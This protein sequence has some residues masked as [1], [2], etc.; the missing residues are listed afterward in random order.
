MSYHGGIPARAMEAAIAPSAVIDNAFVEQVRHD[1]LAFA[2]LQL[3]DATLAE[4]AVQEA[5]TAALTG[6]QDFAGR[7]ALKTVIT[8]YSIHYTKLYEPST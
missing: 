8:S 7:S 2:Q 5:L 3:R 6:G 4:D 1:M